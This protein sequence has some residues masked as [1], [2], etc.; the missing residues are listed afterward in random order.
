MKITRKSIQTKN[1][2]KKKKKR[3]KK[4]VQQ[5]YKITTEEQNKQNNKTPREKQYHKPKQ[6]LPKTGVSTQN[7]SPTTPT[8]ITHKK[9]LSPWPPVHRPKRGGGRGFQV[10]I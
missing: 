4:E 7:A 10:Y 5:K 2:E 6:N 9:A 1:H 8:V 3:K